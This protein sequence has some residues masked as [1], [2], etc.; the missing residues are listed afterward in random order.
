MTSALSIPTAQGDH[1]LT[2]KGVISEELWSRLVTRIVKDEH[3][4]RAFAERIMDQALGFLRLTAVDPTTSYSPS[5]LVDIGWH[6]FIL[7]TREYASFCH[8]VAGHFIHHAPSDE[9]G[10]DYASG[11]ATSTVVAMLQ[12][13][14]A[15][16]E[17]LWNSAADCDK[18]DNCCNGGKHCTGGGSGG[19]V[20]VLVTQG[21]CGGQ[22]CYTC[23]GD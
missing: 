6:T 19:N 18:C 14:F 13:G 21:D 11:R 9:P 16:D 22:E 5:P 2:H 4:E 12:H 1:Q 20:A 7:Y 15:V 8:R 23:V 17:A 10:V 3:M